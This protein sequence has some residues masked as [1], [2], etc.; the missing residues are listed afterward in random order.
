[1][2]WPSILSYM[3]SSFFIVIFNKIV[4]TIFSFH[5]VPFIMCCQSLF[6]MVVF[7]LNGT[8]IRL[9]G[10]DLF[11]VCVLN[12]GNVFFGISASGALNVAMFSALRRVSIFMTLCGQWF[13]MRKNPSMGVVF[14]VCMMILGAVIAS[15]DDLSFNALGYLF[16]MA[17][18]ALTAASQIETK[19]A[20]DNDWTK[21]DIMFWSAC[22]S[23]LVFGLQL[24]NFDPRTFDAWDNGAFRIAF[25]FSMCL[26]FVINWSASW[27]IEKNDPLTLAVAGS[28]KSAVMGLV[29]C[30]GLFD[31][32]YIFTLVN[33]IGLQISAVASLCY[34]YSVH[35][36]SNKPTISTAKTGPEAQTEPV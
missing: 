17:N 15:A 4:L 14:S 18:N 8:H 10:S 1:M 20:M 23:F 19:R 2:H 27:T 22:L 28:T 29:V 11:K 34:V 36:K 5:S 9:P 3:T 6:T 24:I 33:F 26:G 13:V 16:V 30:A 31:P 21:S 32:S 7:L 35:N 25:F 12:V